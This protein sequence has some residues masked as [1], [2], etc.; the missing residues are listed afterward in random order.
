MGRMKT[1]TKLGLVGAGVGLCVGYW[2]LARSGDV[3]QTPASVADVDALARMLIAETSFAR[4]PAEM[5]QIVWVAI[6][7]ASTQGRTLRGVVT[8][9]GMPVWNGGSAYAARFAAASQSPRFEAAKTFVL[10]VLAGKRP[11]LIGTR[12]SFVH[13]SGMPTPPCADNRVVV[14]T[15]AGTRCLPSWVLGGKQV[16]GALFA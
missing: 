8:P 3:A 1:S 12:R 14:G 9:P 11:N 2:F 4:D 10:E 15:N 5:A 16:G 6:N 13:P 7:R